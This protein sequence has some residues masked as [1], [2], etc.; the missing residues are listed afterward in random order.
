MSRLNPLPLRL[1]HDLKL[2]TASSSALKSW[3]QHLDQT[4]IP[5]EAQ[6][7]AESP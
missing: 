2:C 4:Q 5:T 7:G 3:S 1:R 6:V